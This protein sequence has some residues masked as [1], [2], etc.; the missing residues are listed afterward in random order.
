MRVGIMQP[1]LFPYIGYFQLMNAADKFVVYDNIQFTKK[2]WINRNRILVYGKDEFISLPLKKDSDYLNIDQRNLADTFSTE[3]DK[4]LRKIKESY[5]KAPHFENT[6]ALIERV[7]KNEEKNLF[8]FIYHSLLL[9]CEYLDIK[10]DMIVSSK[11]PIDHSLKAQDK[12]IALCKALNGDQYINAIGGT[13]LYSKEIFSQNNIKLN[14]IEA[15]KVAYRQFDNEFVPWLSIIDVMMFNSKE[16][17]NKMLDSF[18][19]K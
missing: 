1:Y 6:F 18:T 14:F 3:K 15:G 8:R 5:K 9:T 2:G 4:L 17:I 16:E 11:L 12:V 10:T 19:L 7:M 13:E